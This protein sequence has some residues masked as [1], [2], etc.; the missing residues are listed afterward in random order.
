[1]DTLERQS[2]DPGRENN[3]DLPQAVSPDKV[4]DSSCST[5][6]RN[7]LQVS[8]ATRRAAL[9]AFFSRVHGNPYV[10]LD[11]ETT[12]SHVMNG[13]VSDEFLHALV[14]V[15]ARYVPDAEGGGKTDQAAHHLR[16]SEKC[17]DLGDVSMETAQTLTLQ[18]VC[19]I[20]LGRGPAAWMKIGTAIRM[21][22]GM[23]LQRRAISD[24]ASSLLKV[25]L[26]RQFTLALYAMD[27]FSV[28]GSNRPMMIS[29]D[30]IQGSSQPSDQSVLSTF[31]TLHQPSIQNSDQGQIIHHLFADIL[32][33]LGQS[34]R[35]LQMGG[36]QGD[37]HFPWH[38]NSILSKL[39]GELTAWKIRADAAISFQTLDYSNSVNVN[40]LCLSWFSYHAILIRLYRQF[41]PLI[42]AENGSDYTSDPWQKETSRKCV[43]HAIKMAELCDEAAGQGYSWPFFTSFCLASAATVLI[44]AKYYDFVTGSVE[45]LVAIVERL[46][47]MLAENPLVE[48]QFY[49]RY[50]KGEF[51]PSHIP[52]AQPN[53]WMDASLD[54]R[55]DL[56]SLGSLPEKL[57]SLRGSPYT[58]QRTG[59]SLSPTPRV[60]EASES[61]S[62]TCY[63]PGMT[64]CLDDYLRL[65]D[66]HYAEMPV[67]ESQITQAYESMDEELLKSVSRDENMYTPSILWGCS[68][69]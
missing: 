41:L 25:D 1:M 65:D 4:L 69:Y 42:M 5:P 43:E 38:Q 9:T 35:Y 61:W 45:Y 58:F 11:E 13:Q 24:H 29:D 27:R 68:P 15:A 7:K 22:Q 28:C 34:N 16:L 18:A 23:E 57:S 47:T 40:W 8:I 12:R 33:L 37:S 20:S 48:S 46:I 54:G 32:R 63:I 60:S 17:V 55:D 66:E 21:A 51:D 67:N 52:F 62:N 53:D 14:A 49:K 39:V 36:V 2:M 64:T 44:H 26:A 19:L 10:F 6:M 3:Q 56:F 50:P 59:G 31:T 30:W